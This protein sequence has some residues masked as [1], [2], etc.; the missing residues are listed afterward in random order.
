MS[1]QPLSGV[2]VTSPGMANLVPLPV[3]V[4]PGTGAF[5]LTTASGIY[6]EPGTPEML[7]IGQ[8][9][10]DQLKAATGHTWPVASTTGAPYTRK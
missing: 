1:C 6:V 7:A 2:S 4:K 10:A 8:Y 3:S 9:L 5:A